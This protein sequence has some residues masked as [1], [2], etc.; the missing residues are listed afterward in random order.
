MELKPNL[1]MMAAFLAAVRP[2]GP[3][4][5]S[6]I[7]PERQQ[8]TWADAVAAGLD[9]DRQRIHTITFGKGSM[10]R[11][12]KWVE[13]ENRERNVYFSLNPCRPQA[14][15]RKAAQYIRK[16]TEKRPGA[17]LP[18]ILA[19]QYTAFDID[20]PADGFTPDV[21]E[22]HVR[23][24]LE[25]TK[26]A[27]TLIWR[28]GGGVQAAIRIKPAVLLTTDDQVRAAK[29]IN[30]GVAGWLAEQ[31]ALK[32][33]SIDNI[34]RVLRVCGT[35][36]WPNAKK[37][38]DG[39]VPVLAGPFTH[40]AG[41]TR[42]SDALPQSAKAKAKANRGVLYNTGLVEP[43]G[44]WDHPDNIPY[45]LLH[46]QHTKDLAAEG[47]SG[48][49]IRTAA[50]LRDWG[51]SEALALDLMLEHWVD[52]CEYQFKTEELRSKINT[53]YH[54]AQ[55]DPGVRT[56]LYKRARAQNRLDEARKE[57]VNE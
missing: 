44:G 6:A 5:L 12:G 38:A 47:V 9:M 10:A 16:A 48:T 17:E 20:L 13:R 54:I 42:T 28:S 53:A 34:D 43:P 3:H 57:F 52:R 24:K 8:M 2:R 14:F 40:N 4:T 51:I 23:E 55:N 7:H 36:N 30:Q 33:D 50:I 32:L 11:C 35:V 46:L 22:Q 31:T 18:D 1:D 41:V 29:A 49:A 21:W 27:F 26:L 15:T 56:V 25:R 37:R 45:A 19:H 39:R